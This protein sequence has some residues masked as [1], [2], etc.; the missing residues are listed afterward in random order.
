MEI[1][2]EL[3]TLDEFLDYRGL[4][5]DQ[6]KHVVGEAEDLVSFNFVQAHTDRVCP[7]EHIHHSGG[8]RP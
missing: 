8:G 2:C 3:T 7:V 1:M 6:Q 4:R 5:A